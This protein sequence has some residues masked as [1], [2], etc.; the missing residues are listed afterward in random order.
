MLSRMVRAL[1][2]LTLV[3]LPAAGC[4]AAQAKAPVERPALEVPPVPPR[5]VE[6]PPP[7]PPDPVPSLPEASA[8]G[9]ST[10][11]T[12]TA[13]RNRQTREANKEPVKP[14]ESKPEPPPTV[15]VPPPAA[16]STVPPLRTPDTPAASD[17]AS[18]VVRETIDRVRKTLD[19]IDYRLLKPEL[20]KEYDNAKQF[21]LQAEDAVGKTN[22]E[23][24]RSLTDK[25]DRI[26]KQLQGR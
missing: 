2:L 22:Y 23:L 4:A 3:V 5:A 12:T 18:R 10:G 15:E 11:S 9:G 7:P 1:A 20:K 19:S 26:A 14:P 16:A 21:L 6:P 13:P 8:P 17:A 24:A 25:A